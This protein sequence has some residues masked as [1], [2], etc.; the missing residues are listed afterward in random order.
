MNI[1][2]IS[3]YLKRMSIS[4]VMMLLI[5]AGMADL[6]PL[7][8]PL[9]IVLGVLILQFGYQMFKSARSRGVIDANMRDAAR[10]RRGVILFEA[11]ETEVNKA[12]GKSGGET[13]MGTKMLIML[14]APLIIFIASGFILNQMSAINLIPKIE[15]WQSYMIGALLSMPV[16]IALTAKMGINPEEV[17]VTP[18]SFIVGE[19]GIVYDHMGQ[20]F[21]LRFPLKKFDVQKKDNFVEVEGKKEAST[22][23]NKL[24]LFSDKTNN[25]AKIL[26]KNVIAYEASK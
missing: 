5:A 14:I 26:A 19:K 6:H 4:I 25:L 9:W 17:G 10:I 16:S 8:Q 2:D 15:P 21:I 20:L 7:L 3:K 1:G 12:K 23:P 11:K 18:K 13:S 24:K 22:I